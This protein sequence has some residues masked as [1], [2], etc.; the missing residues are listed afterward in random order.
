MP[1]LST[2]QWILGATCAL[3]IGFS[4]TGIAGLG[5]AI[6][7][8]MAEVFPPRESTAAML[9]M[10]VVG[11]LFA[12][13]YYR[14]HAVWRTLLA[15]LPWVVPGILVGWLALGRLTDA[16]FK[17]ALGALILALVVLQLVRTRSGQWM[18]KKLPHAWWFVAFV[19]I[20][21]GLATMLGNAAGGIMTVFL[22]AR[23]LEKK[24]FMGTSAWFYLIV[25]LAKVPFSADLGLTNTQ[26]LAFAG[27]MVP[28]VTVGALAGVQVLPLLPQKV[29]DR[30]VL[31]I[32]VLASLR[33]IIQWP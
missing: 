30:I 17:P 19:G 12:V 7:P 28:A 13:A 10:L 16:Q 32:A 8:I 25:N 2:T 26:T 18:E 1:E 4:K 20:V 15:L 31:A 21:A 22:L 14:R 6:V 23:G 27:L 11:D 29:F 33:L 5:I 24:E 9:L 3:L